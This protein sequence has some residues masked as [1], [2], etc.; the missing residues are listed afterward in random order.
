MNNLSL[1]RADVRKIVEAMAAYLEKAV[2]EI[3]PDEIEMEPPMCGRVVDTRGTPDS[4][5]RAAKEFKAELVKVRGVELL[6]GERWLGGKWPRFEFLMATTKD[7]WT[8]DLIVRAFD[9]IVLTPRGA[10]VDPAL[11]DDARHTEI[12]AWLQG[13]GLSDATFAAAVPAAITTVRKW[14]YEG[15]AP[16]SA[17][18]ALIE[19]SFPDC[20]VLRWR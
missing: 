5:K 16:R 14:I 9:R 15:K 20:P 3:C 18:R 13:K 2:A 7:D 12:R 4:F 10:I 8:L 6:H 17:Y 1:D 11:G 19:K